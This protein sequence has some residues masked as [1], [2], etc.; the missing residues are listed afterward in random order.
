MKLGKIA[1]G[2]LA[3]KTFMKDIRGYSQELISQIKAGDGTF[4]HD[5]L[6]NTKCPRCG[7]RM[8]LVKGKNSQMLVC[9]DR[10]CGYRETISRTSNARCPVC[11]KRMELR[12]K[13]EGQIFVC[14]CG[15]KEK[16]SAFQ[17]RRKR[18][19]AGV[20]KR[21]VARYMNQQKKEAAEPL[22]NAF[23][24]ALAGIKLEEK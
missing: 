9:Q 16:L 10:E 18:E 2:S 3:R 24:Q 8:L 23:A 13:G 15:H 4:R 7:K 17:E 6:T 5:N 11:H 1:A 14:S 22:N 20:T 21:D 12:G 19:G